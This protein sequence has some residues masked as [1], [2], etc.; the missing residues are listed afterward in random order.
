MNEKIIKIKSKKDKKSKIIKYKKDKLKNKD[1]SKQKSK[2]QTKQQTKQQSKIKKT[3]LYDYVIIGGGISGLYSAYKIFNNN[4][5]AKVL[6]LEKNSQNKLGGRMRK[7]MFEGVLVNTGAGIGRLNKDNILKKLLDELK[8]KYNTF[9]SKHHYSTLINKN[10]NVEKVFKQLKTSYNKKYDSMTFKEFAEKVLGEKEYENFK[11]CSGYSD[12]E[13]ADIT[14]VLYNYDF[15]DNYSNFKGM[16]INWNL[17]KDK[18]VKLIK[19]KNIKSNCDVYKLR[20]DKKTNNYKIFYKKNNNV[21]KTNKDNKDNKDKDKD[22]KEIKIIDKNNKKQTKQKNKQKTNNYFI[23]SKKVIIASTIDTV[24]KLLPNIPLYNNIKTNSFLRVYAKFSEETRNI[25]KKYV[26]TT[27][28]VKG[29]LQ[30][31]IPVNE[32]KGIYMIAYSDNK[33]A[34]HLHKIIEKYT[35]EKTSFDKIN[36]NKLKLYNYF[37]KLLEK[38]LDIK[39]NKISNK[40][41]TIKIINLKEFYW[42]IGTHYNSPLNN[43][44]KN[45]LDF[46]NKAQHPAKNLFIVGECVALN[47]GWIKGALT[48]VQNIEKDLI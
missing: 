39:K 2:Q 35:S 19:L 18:L 21:I 8:I 41:D 34:N 12:Y 47:Q 13:N 3:R 28:I 11:V 46:I 1:K 30:K 31:I 45:R 25:I 48:S 36:S 10:C 20:Y 32:N 42:K 4:P 40:K 14:D 37:E 16:G 23:C 9:S 17:L 44:F 15:N 27:T 33:N 43:K 5:K 26:P 7:E 6:I 22:N 29:F 38:S 24:K